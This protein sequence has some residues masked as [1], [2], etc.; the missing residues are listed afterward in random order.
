MSIPAGARS[1]SR[2]RP[3]RSSERHRLLEPGHAQVG[4]RLGHRQRLLARIGAVGVDEQLGIAADRLAGGPHRAEVLVGM[5]ADLHLHPRDARRRPAAELLAQLLGRIRGESP[6]AIHRGLL[7]HGAQ[8]GRPGPRRAAAPSGPTAPRRRPRSPSTRFR[9]GRGCARPPHRRVGSGHA[10]GVPP[11]HDAGEEVP[12]QCRGRRV[13]VGVAQ[14]RPV[15]R[16]GLDHDDGGRAPL[17][18][19]RPTRA[20][21]SAPCTPTTSTCSIGTLDEPGLAMATTPTSPAGLPAQE[22]GIAWD[23]SRSLKRVP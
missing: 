18:R 23:S 11:L 13:G 22:P 10:H 19:C 3:S 17:D 14:A 9:P 7:A 21:R 20:R 8:Q 2:R 15:P 12:D 1:R 4:E 6:A 16:D 5:A